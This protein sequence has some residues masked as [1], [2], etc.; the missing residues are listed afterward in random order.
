MHGK[1]NTSDKILIIRNSALGD[2]AMT[3][4]VIYSFAKAYPRKEIYILTR[5]FFSRLFI[6]APKNIKIITADYKKDYKGVSGTARLLRELGKYD[7]TEIADFHDVM[8][9]WEID[10][11]FALKGKKVRKLSKDRK[12]RQ[13]L[14]KEKAAQMPY[15]DR[16]VDVLRQLGY[17]FELTFK[18]LFGDERPESPIRI[19]HPA[20]GIAPFARYKT[21]EY[22]LD[23]LEQVIAEL[24]KNGISVY[25][26][27]GKDDASTIGKIVDSHTNCTSVSG[28]YPIEEELIIMSHM[29]LML[30]MDSANQ[31]L[32]SLAGVRNISIWGSTV[33]YGGFLGYGQNMDD[34]LYA[35]LQCQ[36]CSIAGKPVCPLHNGTQCMRSLHSRKIAEHIVRGIECKPKATTPPGE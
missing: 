34:A 4:P 25:L 27:G 5:P 35:G 22:P 14:L 19:Y 31:H 18:S 24:E 11:Y 33:P 29:D 7:F 10:A 2:V 30:T 23:M 36:P 28:V 21:K 20:V 8:R 16:Y 3:I 32:A 1:D 12:A 13:R 26:F 17:Q 9:S 6:N 15:I